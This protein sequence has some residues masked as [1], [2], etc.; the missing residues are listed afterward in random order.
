[1]SCFDLPNFFSG[2]K[3]KKLL[4]FSIFPVKGFEIFL[5]EAAFHFE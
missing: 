1:M 5:F 4:C 3:R 2:E